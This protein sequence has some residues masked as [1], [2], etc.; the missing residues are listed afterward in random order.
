MGPLH[1]TILITSGFVQKNLPFPH[2]S[3]RA[4]VCLVLVLVKHLTS[5][6][7]PACRC[8]PPT[9]LLASQ[10]L[11]V[12]P[13]PSLTFSFRCSVTL[14]VRF[15]SL[16]FTG[17]SQEIPVPQGFTEVFLLNP[18]WALFISVAPRPDRSKNYY[19]WKY[20]KFFILFIY[21]LKFLLFTIIY[22]F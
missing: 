14:P 1:N 8:V 7:F 22:C 13:S 11:N 17:M 2:V 20:V 15:H 3:Q 10:G 5:P 9:P 19:I 4:S 16:V 18:L 6:S 21:I 12:W